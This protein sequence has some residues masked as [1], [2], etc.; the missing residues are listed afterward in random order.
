VV[1]T[2]PDTPV[3]TQPKN[4]A[5]RDTTPV[6]RQDTPV[7]TQ[8]TQPTQPIDS[9]APQRADSIAA[10]QTQT[11]EPAGTA[12]APSADV[13]RPPTPVT[14][15]T[16]GGWPREATWALIA[17]IVLVAGA[18][19]WRMMRRGPPPARQPVAVT[20]V[21][22]VAG[23]ARLKVAA[24]GWESASE[25]AGPVTRGKVRLNVRIADPRTVAEAEAGGAAL[26]PARVAVRTVQSG[27]PEVTTDG[28][29]LV[30]AGA[31]VQVRVRDGG[32]EFTA[33]GHTPIING[34]R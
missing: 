9:A 31:A 14:Q 11:I 15:P 17:L 6:A 1:V 7:A 28:V 25:G 19:I 3:A 22:P 34:R 26:Q 32:P 13:D 20:P 29:A 4:P 18:A 2:R 8:P 12:N 30:D 21:P 33:D 16:R 5:Q 10:P 23:A 27:A 24:G